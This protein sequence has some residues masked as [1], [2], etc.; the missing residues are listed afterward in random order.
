MWKKETFEQVN[1]YFAADL[2]TVFFLVKTIPITLELPRCIIQTTNAVQKNTNIKKFCEWEI[3]WIL[4][5]NFPS[6]KLR[7][8]FV[9][10][11]LK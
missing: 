1:E 2:L 9:E 11:S 10:I 7:S 4:P 8:S 6:R 5:N 3:V